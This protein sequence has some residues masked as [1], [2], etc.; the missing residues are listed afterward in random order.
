MILSSTVAKVYIDFSLHSCARGCD[1]A[2]LGAIE[3]VFKVFCIAQR[4]IGMA[5][6]TS[7]GK[8]QLRLLRKIWLSM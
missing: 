5:W 2:S 8:I 4:T 3:G 6:L 7:E 1:V